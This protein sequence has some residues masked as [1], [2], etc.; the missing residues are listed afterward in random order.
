MSCVMTDYD[1]DQY[2]NC[3]TVSQYMTL[4][5]S[6]VLSGLVRSA[7]PSSVRPTVRLASVLTRDTVFKQRSVPD[8]RMHPFSALT[9]LGG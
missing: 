4:Y 5:T 9:Q 8:E 7:A 2:S 1:V 6:C 3:W